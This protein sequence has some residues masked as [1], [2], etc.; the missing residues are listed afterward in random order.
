MDPSQSGG[1]RL[2]SGWWRIRRQSKQNSVAGC[3]NRLRESDTSN[4]KRYWEKGGDGPCKPPAPKLPAYA[5]QMEIR[6]STWAFDSN[7]I[8]ISNRVL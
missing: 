5:S 6:A 7:G 2:A 4:T 3:T 1:R 8:S